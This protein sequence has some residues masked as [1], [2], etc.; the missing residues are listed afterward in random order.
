MKKYTLYSKS[1]DFKDG[2]FTVVLTESVSSEL[3]YARSL[4]IKDIIMDFK[5]N[6]FA[7]GDIDNGWLN[8]K[9]FEFNTPEELENRMV[10][11]VI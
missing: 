1:L 2:E 7:H 9:V 5:Y 3:K 8:H 6:N 10:E 11:Y 4:Y